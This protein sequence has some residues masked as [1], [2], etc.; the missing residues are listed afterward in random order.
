[1]HVWLDEPEPATLARLPGAG[2]ADM[3]ADPWQHARVWWYPL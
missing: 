1:V 3:P 2:L